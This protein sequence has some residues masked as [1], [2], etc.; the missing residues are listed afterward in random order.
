MGQTDLKSLKLIS[1]LE[2][3]EFKQGYVE[4]SPWRAKGNN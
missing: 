2:E 1:R 4:D 3:E